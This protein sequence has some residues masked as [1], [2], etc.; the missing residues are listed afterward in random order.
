MADNEEISTA[1]SDEANTP[2]KRVSSTPSTERSW[3]PE[4][5]LDSNPVPS[6]DCLKTPAVD[7]YLDE[8]FES[9]GK[10]YGRES[11]NNLSKVQSRLTNVMG[12]L[13]KL[14]LTLEKVRTGESSEDLDLFDCLRLVEQSVSLLGQAKVS[15]SYTRR[16]AVLFRL[17]GDMKKAKKLLTKHG[18]S[19]TKSHK[20]LFG[21]KFYKALRTATKIR[22]STKEISHHITG[23][24]SR[25]SP[26]VS[27]GKKYSR[28]DSRSSQP[29]RRGPSFQSRG[30]GKSV[31][32]RGK[33]S[34]YKGYPK[35][36]SVK[37]RVKKGAPES[38]RQA[39]DC[40]RN[41]GDVITDSP[42]RHPTSSKKTRVGHISFKQVSAIGRET[43]VFSNQLEIIDTRSVHFTNSHW[44]GDS[45]STNSTPDKCAPSYIS[46]SVRERKHRAGNCSDV[47]KGAIQVVSPMEG[48][49]ISPIFLVPK[50][51]GGSRPVINLKRLNSHIVYQ[52]FK[53]EGL[54]LLKHII[55]EKD[56]M[57]KIDLKDTYFCVP[58]SQQHQP[59]LRFIWGGHTVSVH[60]PPFWSS[61]CPSL[62][63][64]AVE[65]SGGPVMQTWPEDDCLSRRYHCVQSDSGGNIAGQ[66][67]NPLVTSEF[68]FCNQ[69]EE[70]SVR[71]FT[72]HGVPR[73]CDKFKGNELIIA[74]GKNELTH[75][76]LQRPDSGKN[77]LRQNPS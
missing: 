48:E 23:S 24:T 34:N 61:S 4:T 62:L 69:L 9:L 31:S 46:Q 42:N 36:K 47:A 51:D 57:I 63:H 29:F 56:F 18:T 49:L 2:D 32:F 13:G 52:H 26:Q 55:Q 5:V 77:C 53:M 70:I 60:L 67:L 65:T 20:T 50:K 40:K 25:P 64:K 39:P 21:K 7:D 14:W 33:S 75:P 74:K 44:C 28:Q 72:L 12:P 54:H 35:G 76:V 6:I 8:I 45:L 3:I 73:L 19:L 11:D 68:G 58:M 10:S 43:P 22:K 66:G 38:K 27:R 15:L 37:F 41:S 17:T 59:F 1:V 30:G 16:L 71:S